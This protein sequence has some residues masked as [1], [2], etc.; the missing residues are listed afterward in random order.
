MTRGIYSLFLAAAAS[1]ALVAG[2]GSS[3]NNSTTS[4]TTSSHSKSVTTAAHTSSTPSQ[5]STTTTPGGLG[6][7]GAAAVASYCQAA[8]AAT[9]T[10]LSASQRSQFQ[11]I[12]ASL[13]HDNASQLKAAVK[14]LCTEI[15]KI[16]PAAYQSLAAAE[17]AKL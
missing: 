4:S 9:K 12:C 13:G 15:T 2:C 8:L 17:C 16:V 1:A 10:H 7:L 11:N 3:G 6:S 14:S 5:A